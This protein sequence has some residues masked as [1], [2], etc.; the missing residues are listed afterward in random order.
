MQRIGD[1]TAYDEC[2]VRL[3]H[4]SFQQVR[5]LP[6][7]GDVREGGGVQGRA[8]G[9]CGGS[10]VVIRP[11]SSRHYTGQRY[12]WPCQLTVTCPVAAPLRQLRWLAERATPAPARGL[13]LPSCGRNYRRPAIA[14]PLSD[15]SMHYGTRTGDST[16][17]IT[18]LRC[19]RVQQRAAGFLTTAVQSSGGCWCL[20][21]VFGSQGH[22]RF[23]PRRCPEVSD[24]DFEGFSLVFSGSGRRP[25]P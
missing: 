10:E 9:G 21:G 23:R 16:E 1:K 6:V 22:E 12:R 14:M 17:S 20:S 18:P 4:Q 3:R 15:P 25:C 2:V 24:S 8:V 7:I 5:V 13:A 11:P 19:L